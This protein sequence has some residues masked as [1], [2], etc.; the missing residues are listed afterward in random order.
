MT[1]L[2]LFA[3]VLPAALVAPKATKREAQLAEQWERE[4]QLNRRLQ[5]AGQTA[6]LEALETEYAASGA[7]GEAW[8]QAE[9]DASEPEQL[10]H[11]FELAG[12]CTAIVT[13]TPHNTKEASAVVENLIALVEEQ[14]VEL[15]AALFRSIWG[16]EP[17][18]LPYL[19][20]P[21]F[22]GE[23]LCCW[24]P[25]WIPGSEG[26]PMHAYAWYVW[27]RAPR[28]GPSLKVRVGGTKRSRPFQ[29]S[30]EPITRPW[31]TLS[32]SISRVRI[33]AFV[34]REA[35]T[36]D[37]SRQ[38]LPQAL[39]LGNFLVDPLCP[40]TGHS[41]PIR[42]RGRPIGGKLRKFRSDLLKR[43]PDPLREDDEG[44]STQHR[45]RIAPVS[46]A[47]SLRGDQAALLV[48]PQRGGGDPAPS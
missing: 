16:A 36:S 41:R 42:S 48:E 27:R 22:Y 7:R 38:P 13:N 24:R 35:P 26:S 31:P 2:S 9:L 43:Q 12:G 45:A 10:Q 5:T 18:R 14:R 19:N 20:R 3:L 39:K 25:R 29:R 1:L 33:F 11:A 4:I 34:D 15:A 40:A 37:A 32:G 28:S 47:S 17:G 46:A 30:L 6:R 21:S 23:I 8:R 44:N